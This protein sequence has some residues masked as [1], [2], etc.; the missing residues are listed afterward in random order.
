MFHNIQPTLLVGSLKISSQRARSK[1]SSFT[2]YLHAALAPTSLLRDDTPLKKNNGVLESES[3]LSEEKISAW[4]MLW[5]FRVRLKWE[6]VKALISML[7]LAIMSYPFLYL[8]FAAKSFGILF[9]PVWLILGRNFKRR[10]AKHPSSAWKHSRRYL[11]T[12]SHSCRTTLSCSFTFE[13][14]WKSF[15]A[16]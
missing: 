3:T 13:Q 12:S 15:S 16:D 9:F 7:N 14:S 10:T 6:L 11:S 4:D 2:M 5:Q 8:L 1:V